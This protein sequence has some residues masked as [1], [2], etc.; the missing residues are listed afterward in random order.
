MRRR[1]ARSIALALI[2]ALAL[3]ACFRAGYD[4][5]DGRDTTGAADAAVQ[6]ATDAAP[7]AALDAAPGATPDAAIDGAVAHDADVL[8]LDAE[9]ADA[10]SGASERDGG[11]GCP[12]RCGGGR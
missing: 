5:H 12:P 3:S 10:V 7:V 9:A 4:E 11:W 8:A 6:T 1:E 2:A